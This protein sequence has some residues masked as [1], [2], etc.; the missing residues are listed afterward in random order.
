MINI[1]ELS[2]Q[3]IGGKINLSDL[4]VYRYNDDI[5]C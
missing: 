5:L 2:D 3:I 1:S 4:L